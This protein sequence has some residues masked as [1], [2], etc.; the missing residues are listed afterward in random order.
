VYDW[1]TLRRTGYR[2]CI[3]RLKALLAHVDLVRLDH[4]RGF[5]ATWHVPPDARTA[6]PGHWVQ[7]PGADFFEA[8]KRELGHLPFIAED[9][10]LITPD[11]VTLRE[12][13]NLPG[14]RV[15]QFAFDGDSNNPHLPGNFTAN[16]VVYTG[17]HDNNTTR[18]WF[19]S[20]PEQA[21]RTVW[22]LIDHADPGSGEIAWELTRLAWSSGAHLAMVPVQDL[23]NLGAEGRM[24]LPGTARGNWRWRCT[25][26]MLSPSAFERLRDLTQASG[27]TPELPKGDSIKA[28]EAVV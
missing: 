1:E 7:G 21:R 19:E 2:W 6:E 5:C 17:T 13:F 23:L 27:R 22:S 25:E 26:E 24:N 15:L 16:T 18:G 14:I 4:F 28:T 20:L 9:L 12:K 8:A 11:V 3:D 10:G